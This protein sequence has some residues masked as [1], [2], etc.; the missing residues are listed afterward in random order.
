[1]QRI[2]VSGGSMRDSATTHVWGQ[3]GGSA[4]KIARVCDNDSIGVKFRIRTLE[5]GCE[6]GI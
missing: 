2:S 5:K 1:M 4:L 3:Y 6:K